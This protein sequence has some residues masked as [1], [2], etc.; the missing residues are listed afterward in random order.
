M[1]KN[2]WI[3]LLLCVLLL[4]A[5][6]A[7]PTQ[8]MSEG[9]EPSSTFTTAPTVPASSG[10]ADSWPQAYALDRFLTE[11]NH[12]GKVDTS[13]ADGPL[14][15]GAL[16]EA[17]W[18]PAPDQS[19]IGQTVTIVLAQEQTAIRFYYT[20]QAGEERLAV[21]IPA[22]GLPLLMV[23]ETE[24]GGAEALREK[25]AT[26]Q[27]FEAKILAMV[28]VCYEEGNEYVY[29]AGR[30]TTDLADGELLDVFTPSSAA[31]GRYMGV[32]GTTPNGDAI[33]VLKGTSEVRGSEALETDF[34]IFWRTI[35]R[36]SLES[37]FG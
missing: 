20:A 35:V 13:Q 26:H 17:A 24:R 29:N 21:V 12:S 31:A 7:Q 8:G 34:A 4:S 37:H 23:F 14:A 22:E 16:P 36:F 27:S 6:T 18:I 11:V 3:A 10:A 5:C 30:N 28:N 32:F 2:V 1:Q 19:Q 15:P 25:M 33:A 9:T